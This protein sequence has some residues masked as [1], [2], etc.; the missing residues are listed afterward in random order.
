MDLFDL[1]LAE[2]SEGCTLRVRVQ[3]KA[4]T[5]GLAG[6]HDGALKVSLQAPPVDGAANAALVTFL[7]KKVLRIPQS[8][9]VIEHG[10]GSKDK[11]VFLEGLSPSEVLAR[12]GTWT[13]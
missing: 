9:V 11:I 13:P 4:K 6:V 8:R 10:E 5:T 3:P 12:I 7:A 1:T 2:R